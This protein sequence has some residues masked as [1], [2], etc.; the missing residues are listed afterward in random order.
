MAYD[1][2]NQKN[3]GMKTIKSLIAKTSLLLLGAF[4][5]LSFT[6]PRGGE[7]FEI[8]LNGK[9]VVQK[10]GNQLNDVKSLQLDPGSANDE[11]TIK[12]FHCGQIGKNRSLTIRDGQNKI[13]KEWHFTDGKTDMTC[14]VKDIIGTKKANG[15]VTLNLFYSSNE[16]P[17]G[18]QIASLVVATQNVARL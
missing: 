14:K 1:L 8:Y 6:P 4:T 13:L 10:F 11:L 7:G 9:L 15:T 16:L 12:Y 2:F 17:K 18:R 5:L 3:Y